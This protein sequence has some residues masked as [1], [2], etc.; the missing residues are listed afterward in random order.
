MD[1]R[2]PAGLLRRRALFGHQSH[3]PAKR[4]PQALRLGVGKRRMPRRSVDDK[5]DA[6]LVAHQSEGGRG[7]VRAA[8]RAAGDMQRG[9]GLDKLARVADNRRRNLSRSKMARSAGRR[10]GAGGYCKAW[11]TRVGDE[12][13]GF[14]AFLELD[15]HCGGVAESQQRATGRKPQIKDAER[16]RIL[17][18]GDQR[19]RP[20]CCR[21]AGRCR[22]RIGGP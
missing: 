6:I 10:T 1:I 15:R 22:G 13:A 2:N 16:R 19:F 5:P 20:E 9:V 4:I 14:R 12:A 8:L 21:R 11:I 18:E 17:S 3:H 7:R